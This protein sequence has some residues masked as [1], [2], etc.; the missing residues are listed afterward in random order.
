MSLLGQLETVYQQMGQFRDAIRVGKRLLALRQERLGKDHPLTEAASAD[1]GALYGAIENYEEAKPLLTEALNYWRRRNPPAPIQLAR[2]LNDLGIVER[3]TGSFAEAQSLFDEALAIRTRILRPDDLR[4]AYSLNNLASVYLAKGEYAKAISLFDR[5]IDIYRQRGRAAEDSLSNTLL[6]VAMAYKSQGQFDK[7]GEYC[8]EALKIYER[9]FGPDAPGALSLYTALTSL[10][11][12]ANRIDEAA[13]F[14][15]HAWRLCQAGKLDREPVAATVLHHRATI[16]YVRGQLDAAAADWQQALAIQQA[17]GQTAQVARTLNYL[18]KVES[19]RGQ[20][21]QA[22]S[23]YRKALGLAAD[24]S[25]LSGSP[26]SYVLQSGRNS[27]RRREARR[28]ASASPRGREIGRSATGRHGRR[29]RAA[30]RI[31]RSICL[32]LRSVGRLES[33]GR[34]DRRGLPIRRARPQ[35]HVSRSAQPGGSRLARNA[36]RPRSEGTSR[37]RASAAHEARHAARANAE[38]PPA[39]PILSHRS[40]RWPRNTPPRKTC[41]PRSGPR[42]AMPARSIASSSPAARRSVR[43]TRSAG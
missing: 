30:G 32:G 10:S 38:S 34:A 41:S 33:P 4:L 40:P 20:S 19:L 39:P 12:A 23:L 24:N 13:D 11:I 7:S 22:E 1:L 6:N 5:A 8:R 28:S 42:S 18:A 37:A 35:S 26:L 14:N 31:L 36:D 2:A 43:S 17:A 21:G 27:P 9:V 3:A 16:A 25:G 15:R 29:R